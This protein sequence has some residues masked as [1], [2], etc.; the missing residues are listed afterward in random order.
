[1]CSGA[2]GGFLFAAAK[3]R[4]LPDRIRFGDLLL[5]GAATHKLSR[6]LIPSPRTHP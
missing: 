5:L 3:K 1:L 6:A 2:L 4:P